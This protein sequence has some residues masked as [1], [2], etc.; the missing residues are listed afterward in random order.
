M[1]DE[2]TM[3]WVTRLDYICVFLE[4][5]VIIALLAFILFEA[6]FVVDFQTHTNECGPNKR[7]LRLALAALVVALLA[8]TVRV[9]TPTTKEYAAI[10]IVPA[11]AND[12]NIRGEAGE[13]YELAK[14]WL[15][16]QVKE[17]K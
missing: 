13:L 7:I 5:T 6:M 16:E 12:E 10:K 9:F 17:E 8:S 1:I 4:A 15:K 2:S 11:I 3:Y 14:A